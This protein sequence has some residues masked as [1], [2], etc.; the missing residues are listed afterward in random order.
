MSVKLALQKNCATLVAFSAVLLFGRGAQSQQAS[1][2]T[3]TLGGSASNILELQRTV[4][5]LQSEVAELKAQ[6]A[7]MKS[8]IAASNRPASGAPSEPSHIVADIEEPGGGG[9][10]DMAQQ[11]PSAAAGPGESVVK[12]LALS[13]EDRG[14]LDYLK[15]TTTNVMVDGYYSYNFNVPVGRVNALRAY[16]VSSNAFSLNQAVIMFERA[17]DV[18]AGRRWGT[19]VDLQFG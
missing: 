6:M 17:A 10:G 18:E 16:D 4:F 13:Q 8:A 19:R 14:I 9:I 7:F 2:E 1:L 5:E 15:G 3:A 11:S 12:S